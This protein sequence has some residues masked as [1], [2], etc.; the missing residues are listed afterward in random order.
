MNRHQASSNWVYQLLCCVWKS[1]V[2]QAK[3][4]VSEKPRIFTQ[5]CL[6]EVFL[7]EGKFTEHSP[8]SLS[9]WQRTCR[10]LDVI[11]T[12][13]LYTEDK[14]PQDIAVKSNSLMNN[15]VESLQLGLC[16]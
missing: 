2:L 12:V 14:A 10:T 8:N 6:R 7:N 5:D 1:A 4:M 15:I 16:C 11:L 13:N 9:A 3:H